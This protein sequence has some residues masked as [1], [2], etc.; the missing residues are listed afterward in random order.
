MSP[1]SAIRIL[2]LIFLGYWALSATGVK[3]DVHREYRWGRGAVLRV[4]LLITVVLLFRTAFFARPPSDNA[5][6]SPSHTLVAYA[7]VLLCAAGIA[8][9]IWARSHLG[10]NWSPTPSLKAEHELIT[11]GPYRLVRH[12]IY[13]GM[14]FALLGNTLVFGARSLILVVAFVAI[15]ARRVRLEE[16]LMMQQFPE[17]YPEYRERTKAVI[18]FVV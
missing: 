18:P 17:Q 16:R 11:T 15:V 8:F 13:T 5:N 2:W 12:P 7:G 6:A 10:R 14:L 1:N 3:K 9:A 4:L